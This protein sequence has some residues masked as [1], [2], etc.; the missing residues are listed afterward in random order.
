MKH[1]VTFSPEVLDFRVIGAAPG[2]WEIKTSVGVQERAA[3]LTEEVRW[4]TMQIH[5]DLKAEQLI[6][7]RISLIHNSVK[8]ELETT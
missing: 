8:H 7:N 6:N 2:R 1:V 5:V 3:R 4:D